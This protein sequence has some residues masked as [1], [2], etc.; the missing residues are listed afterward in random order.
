M[1]LNLGP[2]TTSS[3]PVN[4]RAQARADAKVISDSTLCTFGKHKGKPWSLVDGGYLRW[5]WEA[6]KKDESGPIPDYIRKRLGLPP[7]RPPAVY[8]DPYK[9]YY[10]IHLENEPLDPRWADI[11]QFQHCADIP[12]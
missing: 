6:G 3:T 4:D 7:P 9:P 1:I 5:L 12:Y 2:V 11:F 10:F 8:R